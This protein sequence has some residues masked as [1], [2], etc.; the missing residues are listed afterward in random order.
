MIRLRVDN[1]R[2]SKPDRRTVR[3]VKPKSHEK[4]RAT[5]DFPIGKTLVHSL[6]TKKT[7]EAS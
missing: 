7:P 6:V 1:V 3:G 5:V 2:S 4:S